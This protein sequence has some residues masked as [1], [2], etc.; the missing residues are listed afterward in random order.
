MTDDAGIW[1]IA[2]LQLAGALGF[3][4]YWITWWRT[5]HKEDWLPEGHHDHE[6]PFVWSD[7]MLALLLVTSAVLL[8]LEEPLG[9][10]LALVAG[11]MLLFLGVLDAAYFARTGM[12]AR[13]RDGIWNVLIVVAASAG[14]L[15]LVVRFA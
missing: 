1:V 10:S 15:F 2:A 8:V 13:E 5:E 7:S 3:A 12:F 9:E 6:A 11:G 4:V 14:G